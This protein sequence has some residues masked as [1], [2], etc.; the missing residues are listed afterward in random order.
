V[1][2]HELT[3]EQQ[4]FAERNHN[5][6]YGFLRDKKLPMDDYYDVVVFGY[7]RAVQQYCACPE[8]RQRFTFGTIAYRKMKDDLWRH[9]NRQSRPS[10]KAVTI[11]IE[12]LRYG[13]DT[14]TMAEI[15]PS[16]DYAQEE[17]DA[18][19]LWAQ[20]VSLLTEEQIAALR[21]RVDGYTDREIAARR[22]RR[23]SDVKNIF[24]DIQ[25][26]AFGLCLV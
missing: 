15:I 20:L 23:L 9:F 17:L 21:L 11:S 7:L 24:T 19:L 22:K 2:S 4:A 18:E 13:G 10:R 5:L 6:V 8:L 14:L 12:S 1:F 26:A 25:A 3:T 16:P